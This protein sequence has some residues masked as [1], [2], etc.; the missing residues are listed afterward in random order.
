[1]KLLGF[2]LSA[3]PTYKELQGTKTMSTE[4]R[5]ALSKIVF[6]VLRDWGISEADQVNFLGFPK[7]TKPRALQRY[8]NDTP[9]PDD[10][11]IT[12]RVT[13]ILEIA[14]ALRTTYPCNYG[15]AKKW[16]QTPH[17]RFNKATPIDLILAEGLGGLI[18][19]RADLDCAYAWSLTEPQKG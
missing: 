11:E 9:L 17:R 10:D 4:K 19:V 5:L 2:L 13:H 3:Q 14:E 15:M 16:L 8:S 7:A 1:M 6:G 12:E 18:A